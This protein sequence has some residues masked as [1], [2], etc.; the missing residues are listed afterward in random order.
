MNDALDDVIYIYIFIVGRVMH[1]VTS[2]VFQSLKLK[3]K[4]KNLHFMKFKFKF[5]YNSHN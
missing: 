5:S 3:L 1:H 4:I 2:L